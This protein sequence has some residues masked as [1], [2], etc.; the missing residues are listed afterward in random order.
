MMREKR[1]VDGFF[2]A[3]VYQIVRQIPRG[4]VV[5]YGGIARLLGSPRAARQVGWAMRVCPDDLPWHRVVRAD[6]SITGGQYAE[7]RRALLQSEGLL[8]LSDGRVNMESCCW[9]G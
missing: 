8:F 1:P 7:I 2:F 9:K 5:S 4:K 6:G 3:A